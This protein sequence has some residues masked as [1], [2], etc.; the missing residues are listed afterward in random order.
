MILNM[1]TYLLFAAET[2]YVCLQLRTEQMIFNN[3]MIKRRIK[4][5]Y[6]SAELCR[7]YNP[8]YSDLTL[9]R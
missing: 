3:L 9:Y 6:N 8:Y 7:Q 5:T 1:I 4:N 2:C